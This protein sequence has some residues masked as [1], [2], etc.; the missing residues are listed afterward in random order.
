MIDSP[1]ISEYSK[2]YTEILKRSKKKIDA[3]KKKN[4]G[5]LVKK[6]EDFPKKYKETDSR[7]FKHGQSSV[8]SNASPT[9]P[10]RRQSIAVTVSS[11][12][13]RRQSSTTPSPDGFY[14]SSREGSP[15][16]NIYGGKLRHTPVIFWI[17]F[18]FFIYHFQLALHSFT[19]LRPCSEK[20]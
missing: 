14:L 17:L 7:N 5:K 1:K 20:R 2:S 3:G 16:A 13:F 15:L 11:S 19:T 12:N 4:K 10:T 9:S 6:D 18:L 8:H